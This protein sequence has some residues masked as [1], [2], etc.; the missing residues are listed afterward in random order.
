[1]ASTRSLFTHPNAP[2]LKIENIDP[3]LLPNAPARGHERNVHSQAGE[4][5]VIEWAFNIIGA[6]SKWCV[7]FGAWDG[8]YLSNT[9]NLIRNAGW[10]AVMIEGDAKKCAEIEV[11]H[12][13]RSKVIALNRMVGFEG[14][15]R[16]D[17]ILAATPIPRDFDLISIDVDGT[18]WHIW[19]ALFNYRP[20]LV[21]IEFNGQIPNAVNFVQARNPSISEGSSLAAMIELGKAK[22]YELVATSGGNGYFVVREE[23][24]KFKIADNSIDAMRISAPNYIWSCYNGK[25]YHTLPRLGWYGKNLPLPA[26]R[27][28]LV[29]EFRRGK[30]L[31]GR[32][33]PQGGIDLTTA[34]GLL[35]EVLTLREL[36]WSLPTAEFNERTRAAWTAA[37]TYLS[38]NRE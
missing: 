22:G 37:K 24:D 10:S 4:D 1:M 5:G 28:Q 34:E 6:R 15:D 20:R 31:Q 36:R 23:F 21:V 14:D 32:V 9:C 26:D 3:R 38:E 7:E 17:A 35:R 2:T 18:D 19:E 33:A 25:V 8:V 13:D 16:L 29:S 12:P 11:N 27:F 30:H